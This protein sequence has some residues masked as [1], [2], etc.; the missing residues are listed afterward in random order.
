VKTFGSGLPFSA[1]DGFNNSGN[2]D[3]QVP[4]RPNVNPGFSNSPTSGV[5]RGC[6]GIPAGQPLGTAA[7]WFDPCAFSLSPPGTYGN[8]GR[9]TINGPRFDQVNATLAKTFAFTERIK[10]QFRA[11]SFNLFNH[12]Q[13][14]TANLNLFNDN[15]TYAGSAGAIQQTAGVAG[16]GGRNIQFGLKLIF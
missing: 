9:L 4:D 10:L 1:N 13:L 2:N 11:E 16:L 15:G 8:V 12:A 6:P 7:R 14:G 3:P 5:T